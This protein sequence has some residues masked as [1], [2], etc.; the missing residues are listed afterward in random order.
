MKGIPGGQ[1]AGTSLISANSTAFESYGLSASLIAPTCSG[2]GEGFT[3]GLNTLLESEQNRFVSGGG[4][5]VFWTREE[6][7]FN[8]FTVLEDPNPAQVQALLESARKGRPTDVDD[9]PFLCPLA[10]RQ[11]WKGGGAGLDGHHSGESQAA[12]GHLVR[13]ATY[14]VLVGGICPVFTG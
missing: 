10:F 5:F 9:G 4:V 7:K 11:R 6:S 1:T 12:S 14:H 2:C 8:F 13:E 3:R